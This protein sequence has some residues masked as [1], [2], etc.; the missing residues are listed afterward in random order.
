MRL[1]QG[2]KL[3]VSIHFSVA[4]ENHENAKDL[5]EIIIGAMV[6]SPQV[7]RQMPRIFREVG[8]EVVAC[9]PYVLAEV[10]EMDFWEPGIESLRML[11]PKSGA[12][13]EAQANNFA[14]GLVKD[15]ERGV[16]F[17]ASNFYAYIGK[18]P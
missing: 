2:S 5:D 14:D 17:G 13:T 9:F 1:S 3:E 15:S 4:Q 8:L 12:M 18:R 11:L 16:F 7:M 10:G 6:T